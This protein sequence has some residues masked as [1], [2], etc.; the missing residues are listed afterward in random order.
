MPKNADVET[1]QPCSQDPAKASAPIDVPLS[2]AA[3]TGMVEKSL[4]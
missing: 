3:C 1:V 2:G 4:A